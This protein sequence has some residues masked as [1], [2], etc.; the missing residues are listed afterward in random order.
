MHIK[1]TNKSEIIKIFRFFHSILNDTFM[2][3]RLLFTFLSVTLFVTANAQSWIDVT[4]DFIIN[5]RY[6]GN[7]VST[8]WSGTELGA[9]NPRENAEH[10][11]KNYN[12]Y[13]E[14]SGLTPGKYRLSLDA[15]YRMGDGKNDYSL[16]T[17][18]NYSN[19]QH[20]ELYATSSI[21]DYYVKIVPA[22]SAALETS[23]GG[24]ASGV[25][26]GGW[27][28]YEV[29]PYIPNNME[30]AYYWFKAGY[31]DNILE[32]EVGSDGI[33]TI[34]IRKSTWINSDWTCIDNWKLEYYGTVTQATSLSISPSTLEMAP[35]ETY[36][37][38]YSLL[39]SDVTYKKLSWK[40]SN[41]NVA[42]VDNNGTVTALQV[43][44]CIITGTTIDG[45]NK[46]STCR[47]S[48]VKNTATSEN[49]VINEIMSANVDVYMDPNK[50][51]GSWVEIYNPSSKSVSLGG[52]YV[53]DDANDLKK[54]KL[55]DQYGAVPA[56]G[57]AILNFDH[58]EVWTENAYRQIDDKLDCDGGEIIISDGTTIIARQSYP[59]AKSRC[60]Y[61]RTTDGGTNWRFTGNPTPGS[62]NQSST[63]YA[64]R[65]LMSPEPDQPGQQFTGTLQICV[66]IPDGATLVYTTDGTTPTLTNGTSSPTGIFNITQTTCYRFRFFKDGYLPS[67]VTTRSYIQW[68]DNQ[69]PIS[70]PII[71]IVTDD[72][73]LNDKDIGVFGQGSYGRPGNG[74]TSKCN[75]NM[76]WDRPVSFEFITEDNEC[77]VS[78][79]CALSTCGGW[80]RAWTPHAFKLKADKEYDLQ[81]TF[82]NQFFADK[83]FLRHKTLQIRNGGNDTSNRIKDAGIQMIV[84]S[85]GINVDYQEWQP[86]HVF[87][88]GNHYAVL[89]MR[90]PNNKDFA[91]SNKGIDSDMMDQFEISPDSG[92]VQMRGTKESFSRLVELSNDAS[93]N[94]VYEEIKQLLDID[95]YINYMAIELYSGNWDWPQ[96][97]VK[98]YRDQNNGKFRFVLFDL[99]GALST[100]TP[101]S[102]F[103]GKEWYTFD[104]LHGYDYSQDRSVEGDRRYLQ[105][106]FVTL[107][108]NLLE[109][110]E[111]R[112]RFID[113]FCIIG[114]SVF[115]PSHVSEVVSATRDYLSSGGHVNPS[116]TASTLINSYNSNY[117]SNMVAQLKTNSHSAIKSDISSLTQQSVKLSSNIKEGKIFVN[118]IE[119]PYSEFNGYLF[120]PATFKAV[121]PAGYKFAGWRGNTSASRTGTTLFANGSSWY[122]YD[123]GSL[124]GTDWKSSINTSWS[125][126]YAPLG[127]FTS[128]SNN[129]RGYKTTLSY[130][131]NS[132]QKYPTY[133][134]TKSFNL[135]SAP[136]TDDEYEL[137]FTVDDGFIVYINGTE[138]GRYN[139]PGGSVSYN[140]YS[141][142]Y[143]PNNPDTGTLTLPSNLFKRGT[144]IIAV[145]V[146]NNNANSTDIEWEASLTQYSIGTSDYV[147]TSEEYSMPTSGSLNLTAC[148]ESMT[149]AELTS[150]N[151][152]PLKVNEISASNA[153]Y[154]NDYFKRN[155]WIELYNPTDYDLD[156]AG[157]YVSDDINQP[158]KYQ[159]P[160]NSLVNT[161][162]PSKGHIIIWADKLDPLTQLHT[163]FKLGNTDNEMVVITSSDEFVSNN[164]SYFKDNPSRKSFADGLT[165][166]I[167][168]GTETCGRYPDGT[169]TLYRMS[170]ATIQNP[171]SILYDEK[172]YGTDDGISDDKEDTF[173]MALNEGWNWISHIM[174]HPIKP[175]VFEE[176]TRV[177]GMN[178][179]AYNDIKY[180]MTGSLT[181][182]SAG[183]LYKI[184][185][186]QSKTYTFTD[187][188][189][190]SNTP[191][192]VRPGWNWIGY[193][194]NGTQSLTSSLPAE[195]LDEGDIIMG[196]DGFS[197]YNDGR[198]NGTLSSI[199]SGK[200]YMFKTTRTKSLQFIH[201]D[202]S[203]KMRRSP[204]HMGN[205]YDK[206]NV[207]KY[208][209]PNIMGLIA[210]LQ[211]DK[212]LADPD[213]FTLLAYSDDECV[214]YS[215][216]VD[217]LYYLTI[218]G[219]MDEDITF[220]AID[221]FD[222]NLYDIKESINFQSEVIGQQMHPIH[223]TLLNISEATSITQPDIASENPGS[224]TIGKSISGYYSADGRL[225]STK[226]VALQ[227]G[228]Y[229]IKYNDGSHRKIQ[230]R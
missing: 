98:G 150:S 90:E 27:G 214:G 9:A 154:V 152:Q 102:T 220:K 60:S 7:D 114:G 43:G 151:Y 221:Q 24:A 115:Q 135:S 26:E 207:N 95:E 106:E 143:A 59:Q 138:A 101:F 14:I 111:F 155:D 45:S 108:K 11:S 112:R 13:Q 86:V 204:K 218:Y 31:Y 213:R 16:Y 163:N 157:L 168:N 109:N 92:Y 149:D 32:C 35:S 127:Y 64:S 205:S 194:C 219:D 50:N 147:S 125:S 119:L 29:P 21:K 65:Q 4:D 121:A 10:Y 187:T 159:I 182:L 68:T 57:Y 69:H 137:S 8:G 211:I 183:N 39:P 209:H 72:K 120:A 40:S 6:D 34:G 56:N 96:N 199:E 172:P 28:W 161:I 203:V 156:V 78:Q 77:V 186:G 185:T 181:N 67:P 176:A 87:I 122:Y 79:E 25:G 131:N 105:I 170:R 44:T 110:D 210:D 191:I 46:S 118:G 19:Y 139:M 54:N 146:H 200:G 180:G 62:S 76:D 129:S 30:A 70:F 184:Q 145:E 227:K 117:N 228:I 42:T 47:I 81:N 37:L 193:T 89:N 198:W 99:D 61:A 66:N 225:L 142:S 190:E 217:S 223:L 188:F 134:F 132:S 94:S 23:L 104:T 41:T 93:D 55:I 216:V 164:Q 173:T 103:F 195:Q 226:A 126:G 178:T 133:Y 15:F 12:T 80:S 18:G 212:S 49:V 88:N 83:P 113:T 107:F 71:S 148:F 38:K 224:S 141:S 3:K 74:Q 201:T 75:W 1:R 189:C 174:L 208:S 192:G 51:Y 229:I 5:P 84:A 196:Q 165:Y 158:N 52:L 85:S 128:D 153:V 167:H 175:S 215:Q 230:I 91:S 124:D 160:S 130:G 144:N 162:I 166:V 202:V 22:S 179:E 222:G 82:Q 136:S 169:R 2:V 73:H 177:V 140:T 58:H 48:V 36:P 197:I 97:N 123:K 171:N 206:Y 17:S 33:L 100:S 20:A 116:S 63:N 53:S